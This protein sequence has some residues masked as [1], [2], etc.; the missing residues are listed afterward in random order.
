[1]TRELKAEFVKLIATFQFKIQSLELQHREEKQRLEM[2]V[3]SMRQKFR[4]VQHL[5]ANI[6]SGNGGLGQSPIYGSNMPPSS[7]SPPTFGPHT[8]SGAMVDSRPRHNTVSGSPPKVGRD[9]ASNALR[10]LPSLPQPMSEQVKSVL[11]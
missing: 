1:V 2:T 11:S 6:P 9:V 3:E 10:P 7:T 8:S 4:A 5:A